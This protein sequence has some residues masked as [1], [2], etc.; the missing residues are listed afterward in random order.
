[1]CL[2]LAHHSCWRFTDRI[3]ECYPTLTFLP[4]HQ[5]RI[6]LHHWFVLSRS[7]NLATILCNQDSMLKLST[8][9]PITCYCRPIVAPGRII[10]VAKVNHRFNRQHMSL[11]HHSFCF[12]LVIM[13][14]IRGSVKQTSN[15]MTTIGSY[16]RTLVCLSHTMYCGPQVTVQCTWFYHGQCRLETFECCL[17]DTTSICIDVTNAECFL[18]VTMVSS[19]LSRDSG[20][21][22]C[23]Y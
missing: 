5:I 21:G 20:W 19:R 7:Q 13:R 17:D 22:H 2:S 10:V 16:H 11:F 23:E 8:P 9:L 15:T 18:Q 4:L 12:I 1:M 14:H 6:P 3:R